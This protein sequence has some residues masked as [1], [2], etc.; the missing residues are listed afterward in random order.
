MGEKG[1][2]HGRAKDDVLKMVEILRSC[3]EHDD[4]AETRVFMLKKFL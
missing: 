2:I 4:V 3:S 1:P